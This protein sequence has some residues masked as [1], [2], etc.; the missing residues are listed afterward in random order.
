MAEVVFCQALFSKLRDEK[1]SLD[2]LA[3]HVSGSQTVSARS[4]ERV[5]ASQE[6]AAYNDAVSLRQSIH[7]FLES[8]ASGGSSS[9]NKLVMQHQNL[10]G[11][12]GEHSYGGALHDHVQIAIVQVVRCHGC[13][14]RYF[15]A[16]CLP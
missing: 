6:H 3:A 11:F 9:D 12:F 5:Q 14:S 16:R 8:A 15:P 4:D 1:V 2:D 7:E 13:R 10:S